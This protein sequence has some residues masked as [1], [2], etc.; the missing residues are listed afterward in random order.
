VIA[1]EELIAGIHAGLIKRDDIIPAYAKEI[2]ADLESTAEAV[3]PK[4]M[5]SRE[6]ERPDHLPVN[7]YLKPDNLKDA[8]KDFTPETKIIAGATDLF[9]EANI[10]RQFH[11]RYLDVSEV[12][13]MLGIG[14]SDGKVRIGASVTQEEVARNPLI[15]QYFPALCETIGIMSSRQIRNVATFAGNICNAS[16]IADGTSALL[17]LNAEIELTN[18]ENIKRIIPLREFYKGYK[19]TERRENEIL[20]AIY[21][22]IVEY[23][24]S[25][26]IK[27]SKRKN[28]DI[29]SV[30]SCLSI[31]LKDNRIEDVVLSYGGVKEYPA[32]A[33]STMQM[34]K[35][36][37]L[38]DELLERAMDSVEKEFTPISDV[39]GS[40]HYRGLLI[41][42]HLKKHFLRIGK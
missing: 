5:T 16:P 3:P 28:V 21:L 27:S 7:E 6:I 15:K 26:F 14:E 31:V 13:E 38:N 8:L 29:S 39:R 23:T 30:N 33:L 35:G 25:G 4:R 18:T 37:V 10:R 11:K 2:Q 40:A 17:G 42:N 12:S 9:V 1:G 22:P 19:K 20:T 34:M 32:L 24:Y 36:E 41:R